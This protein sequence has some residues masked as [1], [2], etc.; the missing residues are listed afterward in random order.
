MTVDRMARRPV[1]LGP[2]VARLN[3]FG[4]TRSAQRVDSRTRDPDDSH[5][6]PMPFNPIGLS[7]YPFRGFTEYAAPVAGAII[8]NYL[9]GA[10][11]P[12]VRPQPIG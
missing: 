8:S 9:F 6:W 1:A 10:R 3:D 2:K 12:H 11:S 5:R 4:A 7:I